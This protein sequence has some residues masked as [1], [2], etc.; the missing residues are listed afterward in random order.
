MWY[1]WLGS[2]LKKSIQRSDDMLGVL[3]SAKARLFSRC[4]TQI[5]VA[6]K[7]E[8]AEIVNDAVFFK[9]VGNKNGYRRRVAVPKVGPHASPPVTEPAVVV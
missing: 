3:G 7:T 4:P 1:I 6:S 2:Q 5:A 9:S 8:I